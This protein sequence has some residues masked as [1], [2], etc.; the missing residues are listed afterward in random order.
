VKA[1]VY[2]EYGSPD[3]LRC[4]E[5]EKPT[6][7]DE[8]V[9]IKVRAASVNPLDWHFMRGAPYMV[10]IMTGLQ[11]PERGRLG[12]DLAG[13]VEAV[14]RSVTQFQPGDQVF[15]ASLGAF[16]EYVCA[17][18]QAVV[19]KPANLTFEQAAAMPTAGLTALQALRKGRIQSGQKVLINGAAGGVGTFAVPIAKSLGAH[20]T[21][22]CSTR[23]VSLVRSIGADHVIDYTH[24]DFTKSGQRYDLIFDCVGNHSLSAFRRVI[25]PNGTYLMVGGSG[26]GR[27]IG[28]LARG[29]KAILWSRFVSQNLV[30]V[31]SSS[32]KEDLVTLKQ[33]AESK[34]FTPIVDRTYPLSEVPKA[35]RY[36]EEGHARG[37]VVVA[38]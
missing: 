9:L 2:H 38:L 36:L 20:V 5:I 10:R 4:E 1:I 35:I 33:L 30:M 31:L 28:P 23:N 13:E 21:G 17:R 29:L 8:E 6:A 3:I 32:N 34:T 15:G 12:V 22:V 25:S 37:K 26:G 19:L 7:G 27:W 24:E 18:E 14:G 11:K 16:A